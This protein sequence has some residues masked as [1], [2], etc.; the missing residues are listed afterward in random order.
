MCLPTANKNCFFFRAELF[1]KIENESI[2]QVAKYYEQQQY[3]LQSSNVIHRINVSLRLVGVRVI[4]VVEVKLTVF[5]RLSWYWP[6]ITSRLVSEERGS[7]NYEFLFKIRIKQ[8]VKHPPSGPQKTKLV[9]EDGNK[10]CLVYL[11]FLLSATPGNLGHL[12]FL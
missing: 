3:W 1:I 8:N 12:L 6:L 9:A 4:S 11:D 10:L 2:N 5:S 7:G